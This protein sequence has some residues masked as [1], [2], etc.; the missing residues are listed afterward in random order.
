[1]TYKSFIFFKKEKTM[2]K[3][4]TS[5]YYSYQVLTPHGNTIHF[6][7][8]LVLYYVLSGEG[9]IQYDNR[10]VYLHAGDFLFFSRHT[11]FSITDLDN[12]QLLE[13]RFLPSFFQALCPENASITFRNFYITEN[14][15]EQRSIEI[16]QEIARLLLQGIFNEQAEPLE[17]VTSMCS[18]LLT[19]KRHF[20]QSSS[21]QTGYA[22]Y[23][24]ER[25]RTTLEYI[26][27]NYTRKVPLQEISQVLGLNP[28]YFSA[29]F[30]QYFHRSFIDYLN[31]HRIN[32]S[33]SELCCGEKN[34]TQIAFD[35][36][37]Q[38]YKSYSNAFQKLFH[39]SP[40]AYRNAHQITI[41]PHAGSQGLEVL[42]KYLHTESSLS[43]LPSSDVRTIQLNL[44]HAPEIARDQRIHAI[45]IGS[46]YQLLQE[47]VYAHLCK[48]A[49]DLHCT[50]I[51]FRDIFCDLLNV[52]TEPDAGSPLFSWDAADE[53]IRKILNLHLYP[54]IEIGFMPRELSSTN[55]TLGF[56][57]RPYIGVP[58]SYD[59][60]A[61]LVR[62][63][64]T[65]C[66]SQYGITSMEH[67][68]FDFWDTANIRSSNG[69][70]N[71]TQEEFFHL[72]QVT[73]NVF[74][75]V[76]PKLKL[77]SPNF[78]FPAGCSWYDD[79]LLMCRKEGIRPDFLALHLY[80][81]HDNLEDFQGIFPYTTTYNYLPLTN[82][83]YIIQNL[84]F[85]RQLK[86]KY[87]FYDIPI[88]V[89][90]WNISFYLSDLIRDTAFMATY[91]AKTWIQTLP[92]V[93]GLTF[94]NLSDISE[95]SRPSALL[96][97]GF[98]GL[99]DR[100]GIPKPAYH[101]LYLLHKLD[102]AV[103][104]Y[105]ECSI[106]TRG[107]HVY[108]ILLF[109]IS[110]YEF[111]TGQNA[112]FLS[113]DYRYHV[114]QSTNAYEFQGVFSVKPG[115]YQITSWTLN[116]DH[117]CV[118][119]AWLNMG[120]PMSLSS[121]M[122]RALEHDSCP[123]IHY[124]QQHVSDTLKIHCTLAPHTVVLYEITHCHPGH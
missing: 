2:S 10:T 48:A 44:D 63:F 96:F 15:Q 50:H 1:L 87:R 51:H 92:L 54:Y 18:L 71:G 8:E 58:K 112:A 94:C 43:F 85:L 6:T 104:F 81:C 25:I 65:H 53:I 62:S 38:T 33:L 34:I 36:G 55:E 24:Q 14:T 110:Q 73:W 59:L 45:S 66:V 19:L 75:E 117:G 102:P 57:Y 80:S 122:I 100:N 42:R 123:K 95:H 105:D 97:P 5:S 76:S 114:F 69:Y 82:S 16:Y 119:D 99:I 98:Q 91:I 46:G 70:W 20:Y 17:I 90:E 49:S 29:F 108:H 7:S 106:V 11:L 115:S 67:W 26:E 41:H 9:C 27:K 35:H 68:R 107:D 86:E 30:S 72:Y 3:S 39:M 84:E 22:D 40:S 12:I 88:L 101:A 64:L 118:Y 124:E 116:R 120:S 103:L 109:N 61:Q 32:N 79:F 28:Q 89:S 83:E 78:S 23:V 74:R 56:G 60:W 13:I 47:K 93:Q 111:N 37:F 31:E 77:G 121:D 4:L 21:A 113:D 52:Y